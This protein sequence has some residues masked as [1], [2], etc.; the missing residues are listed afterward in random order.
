M[1]SQ[2]LIYLL[3]FYEMAFCFYQNSEFDGVFVFGLRFGVELAPAMVF[4]KD[5][6]VKPIVYHGMSLLFPWLISFVCFFHFILC[7]VHCLTYQNVHFLP[8]GSVNRSSFVQLIEQNK[9]QGIIVSLD[10][11]SKSIIWSFKSILH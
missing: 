1:G 2:P 8:S 11:P 4:L 5:P 7:S 3:L 10:S 9:Q 6:G